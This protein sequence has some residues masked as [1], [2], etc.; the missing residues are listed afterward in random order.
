MLEQ[1]PNTSFVPHALD[2]LSG[3]IHPSVLSAEIEDS[4]VVRQTLLDR[5]RQTTNGDA[6]GVAIAPVH[7]AEM[8]MLADHLAMWVSLIDDWGHNASD[9]NVAD[10]THALDGVLAGVDGDIGNDLT[11]GVAGGYTHSHLNERA[12][13]ATGGNGH[14]AGYGGWKDGALAVR[15][16]AAYDWGNDRVARFVNYTG[17]SDSLSDRQD[18]HTTQVFGEAGYA[19]S[20]GPVAAEP[21]AG[22]AFVDAGTGAFLENGGAS[23]LSSAG[24]SLSETYSSLGIRLAPPSE[25]GVS[26]NVTPH[27]SI[28]WEHMFSR[29]TPAEIVTF[30]ATGQA[31][32]TLG[33]TID[34]D[35][36]NIQIGLDV[37]VAPAGMLT[38]SYEGVQSSR[39]RDN[40]LRAE[41]SWNF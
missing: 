18:G 40:S 9:G 4:H 33:M 2:Q 36:A 28:S 21:F 1:T 11:V 29:L 25:D 31:F 5:L 34:R 27:A 15:L 30:E 22:L 17:F 8:H 37:R 7:P 3:E 39:L 12:S 10:L 19:A 41:L 35:A 13:A 26:L 14:I 23:A 20:L 24:S 32:R 38:F 16:A 6:A